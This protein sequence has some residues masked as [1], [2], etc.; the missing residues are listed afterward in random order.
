MPGRLPP[1]QHPSPPA[2]VVR[3]RFGGRL[4]NR[5]FEAM[6]AHSLAERIPGLAAT[7]PEL[8]E[9][10]LRPRALKLPERHLRIE[11]HRVDVARLAYLLGADIVDGID[12][13]AL[14]FRMDLLPS[15]ALAERLF[16]AGLA[17]GTETGPDTLVISIRG[18]E[19][20]AARHPGYRP[21]PLA[22]YARLVAETG[23]R[24]AFV[25]QVGDDPYSE[26]LRARFPQALFL[27]SR[28]AMEDFATLRRAR[29]LCL[30]IS[31]FAWLAGWLSAA[32]AI[33]LPVAG[34]YDPRLRPQIDLLPL[35]D[36]R[37]RFHLF[38]AEDWGGTAEELRVAI[39]G[40][41]AGLALT[42]E[43]AA[44]LLAS[45]PPAP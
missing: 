28:G 35:A 45:G 23:L 7:G 39:E 9:W 26:A 6:L 10:G 29:H 21:L 31:S 20:L 18:A 24:P 44:G 25:G 15:R 34:I 12:S 19:I 17:E 37:Y 42:R 41:E 8:P 1:P 38:P 11:G 22:F 4:G 36:P 40:A 14:G 13:R 32:E 33:H 5:M 3:Y 30:S 27:P 2:K 43:Q 16:P